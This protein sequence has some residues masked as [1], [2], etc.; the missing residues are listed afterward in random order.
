MHKNG[1][2]AQTVRILVLT[3]LIV[4]ALSSAWAAGNLSRGKEVYQ[5]ATCSACHY[6]GGNA[7]TPS[8]PIKGK[9]FVKRYPDDRLL[10]KIVRQGARSSGMPSFGQD[11]VSDAEMKDLIA[12]I[13][14][15][16]PVYDFANANDR[17]WSSNGKSLGHSKQPSQ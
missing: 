8:K 13:R 9:E 1:E 5:K 15:L 3:C 12:Y 4:S 7:M 6:N 17:S 11:I 2:V 10:E 14:S 16:T